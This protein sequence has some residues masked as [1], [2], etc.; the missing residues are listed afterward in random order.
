MALL[1]RLIIH[2]HFVYDAYKLLLAMDV[3]FAVD[4]TDMRLGSSFRYEEL[5]LQILGVEFFCEIERHIHFHGRKA[6]GDRISK[7]CIER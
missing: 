2:V 3:H 7:P 6:D 5:F 4:M 1:G